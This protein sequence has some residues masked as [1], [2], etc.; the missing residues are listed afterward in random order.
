MRIN[1]IGTFNV[2]R[3]VAKQMISQPGY[4]RKND[5]GVIVNVSS[6][7]GIEGQKGQSAYAASKAAINGL[8]LPMARDL[9]EFKIRVATIA[10]G[11]FMTPMG[12]G[13]PEKILNRLVSAAAVK[14]AGESPE[15]AHAVKYCI[16]NEYFTG[17]IMRLD[18]GIRFPHF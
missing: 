13:M 9:G 4:D 1:V 11:I 17:E 7:A 8:T 6:V 2:S 12:K 16:E 14:R 15:F 10:P 3:L 18:G 5:R